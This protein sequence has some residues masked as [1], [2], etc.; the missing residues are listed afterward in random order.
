M[1]Q[2]LEWLAIP[3]KSYCCLSHSDD[4]DAKIGSEKQNPLIIETH[5]VMIMLHLQQQKV[6]PSTAHEKHF[7]NWFLKEAR[8]CL[9]NA[10][11]LLLGSIV[12]DKN[13]FRYR[14]NIE[15]LLL[16]KNHSKNIKF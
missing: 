5:T 4:L 14:I 1:S 16:P 7:S 6:T 8:R 11:Q 12:H 10:G 15:A 9:K 13:H 2:W 3:A